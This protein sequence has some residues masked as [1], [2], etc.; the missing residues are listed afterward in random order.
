MYYFL[1]YVC[2][3]FCSLE[4]VRWCN[5]NFKF[6]V[7]YFYECVDNIFG[8]EFVFRYDLINLL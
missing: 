4:F 6:E 2:M 7:I 5:F 3:L 8:V 1:L